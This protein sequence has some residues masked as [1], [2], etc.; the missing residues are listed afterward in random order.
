MFENNLVRPE[1]S[2]SSVLKMFPSN[3]VNTYENKK[4][5]FLNSSWLKSVFENLCFRDGLA[6][7]VG[8]KRRNK[9]V[10]TNLSGLVLPSTS[11][12]LP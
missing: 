1:F 11:V 12:A 10:F 4:P 7:M 3:T 5:S 8:L 9:A 6:W 2:K